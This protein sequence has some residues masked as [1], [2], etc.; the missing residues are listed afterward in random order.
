M[1]ITT[2]IDAREILDEAPEKNEGLYNDINIKNWWTLLDVVMS[3]K[4]PEGCTREEA[5]E[6]FNSN[7][8][9]IRERMGIVE[10]TFD[11]DGRKFAASAMIGRVAPDLG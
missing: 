8:D 7:E 2:E 5:V 6:F 1:R 3:T 9:Y 4:F 11:P 10:R